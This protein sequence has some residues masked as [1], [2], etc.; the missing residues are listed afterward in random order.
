MM[1]RLHLDRTSSVD[2]LALLENLTLNGI[3]QDVCINDLGW[4]IKDNTRIWFFI[5]LSN[6]GCSLFLYFSEIPAFEV[7]PSLKRLKKRIMAAN[8]GQ[9]SAVFM[10]GR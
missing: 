8:R 7:L 1:Q 2:P 10:S 3:T 5:L 4:L 6:C 9:Y